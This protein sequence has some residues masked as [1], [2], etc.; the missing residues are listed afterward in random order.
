VVFQRWVAQTRALAGSSVN[1]RAPHWPGQHT[2]AAAPPRRR[3]THRVGDASSAGRGHWSPAWSP[4]AIR[5]TSLVAF[6]Y[7]TPIRQGFSNRRGRIFV[8]PQRP[9]A[10][11][12]ENT[13]LADTLH[14]R[15]TARAHRRGH[16]RIHAL[17]TSHRTRATLWLL[18]RPPAS[19]ATS[20]ASGRGSTRLCGVLRPPA[21]R[22]EC[23]S[24]RGRDGG[25]PGHDFLT[26]SGDLGRPAS[27][28]KFL[29]LQT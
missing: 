18:P 15:A 5:K 19:Y 8:G 24:V 28:R 20:V 22:G 3:A 4:P 13:C 7:A 27:E 2:A 29:P 26:I 16:L 11:V 14:R 17:P 1:H 6:S 9:H 10:A 21:T 23:H 12:S 25:K